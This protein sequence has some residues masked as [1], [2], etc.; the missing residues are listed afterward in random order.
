MKDMYDEAGKAIYGKCKSVKS[1]QGSAKEVGSEAPKSFGHGSASSAG[2]S[3]SMIPGK[4]GG[5]GSGY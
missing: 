3:G 4:G 5:K 1:E 2:V